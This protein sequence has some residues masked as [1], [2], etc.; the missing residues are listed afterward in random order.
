MIGKKVAEKRNIGSWTR[1]ISSKSCQVRMNVVA[2]T[3][4]PA[5]ANPI[6]HGSREREQ[7]PGRFDQAE[8]PGHGHERDRVEEATEQRPR[9]LANCHVRRPDRRREHR[10]V[11][12][13]VLQLP[14]HI[15][16]VVDRAVHRCGGQQRRCDEARVVDEPSSRSRDL[17][18]EVPQPD[19]HREE[20][21]E[22]L[23]DAREDDHPRAA[24]DHQVALEEQV[25]PAPGK[26]RSGHL[27]SLAAYVRSAHA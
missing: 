5:N 3:P 19:A 27:S 10:V 17:P 22:R 14:E 13:H 12:L 8:S 26:R 4:R 1:P 24:V 2:A 25:G 23:E 11:G 20:I 9:R 21:E 7:P 15:R 6:T 18:D 16:R